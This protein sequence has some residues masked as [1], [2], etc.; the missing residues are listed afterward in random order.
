MKKILFLL[1]SAFVALSANA[2]FDIKYRANDNYYLIKYGLD[3]THVIPKGTTYAKLQYGNEVGLFYNSGQPIVN[4]VSHF[5]YNINGASVATPN[6]LMDSLSNILGMPL[7]S[8]GGGGIAGVE[9]INGKDGDLKIIA[10]SNVTIDN[11][12]SDTIVINATGGEDSVTA[13]NGLRI[14]NDSSIGLGGV[15]NENTFIKPTYSSQLQ[16][17]NEDYDVGFMH[18]GL[19]AVMRGGNATL[20]MGDDVILNVPESTLASSDYVVMIDPI[21]GGSPNRLRAVPKSD[22][23]GAYLP[24]NIQDSTTVELNGNSVVFKGE[25]HSLVMNTPFDALA[26]IGAVMDGFRVQQYDSIYTMNGVMKVPAFFGDTIRYPIFFM[27]EGLPL[28]DYY[29]L[30]LFKPL[31]HGDDFGF[32]MIINNQDDIEINHNFTNGG[33]ALSKEGDDKIVL[34][35]NGEITATGDITATGEIKGTT[36]IPKTSL[37]SY[38]QMQD[39][40]DLTSPNIIT[41]DT[42][43]YYIDP[44]ISSI[45][46]LFDGSVDVYLPAVS[47]SIGKSIYIVNDNVNGVEINSFTADVIWFNGS[48]ESSISI[49]SNST[50][51]LI[52]N[53]LYWVVF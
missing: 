50:M 14:M 3:T 48:L 21:T 29:K 19:S 25:N 8:V 2:Q 18:Y 24:L 9:H 37:D 51:K 47:Q 35:A 27:S 41:V 45:V 15:L 13:S 26:I 52:S 4:Y 7:D 46:T 34:T 39:I 17:Y 5:L 6:A 30:A 31:F 38:A 43:T 11:S 16:I 33:Y 44:G 20:V 42:S 36:Y 49:P 23:S 28:S 22:F 32:N 1:M 53:G 12:K 40:F 10:G